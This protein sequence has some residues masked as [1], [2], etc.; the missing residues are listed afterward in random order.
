MVSAPLFELKGVRHRYGEDFT[1]DVPRLAVPEGSCLGLVGPNGS[2]K[3]TLLR[4]LGFIEEP[5]EG[6]LYYRG[7][8]V[9]AGG[10]VEPGSERAGV[11]A[12]SGAALPPRV[13]GGTVSSVASPART[14]RNGATDAGTASAGLKVDTFI[15]DLRR[16]TAMLLQNPYL[17]KKSV[18]ENVVY[19]LR[20][21][22]ETAGLLTRAEEALRLVGLDP[23]RYLRRR[24]YA[25][26]GG[27]SHR[28][29]LAARLALRPK[30]LLLDEPT[31]SVDHESAALMK[32]AIESARERFGTTLVIASH[33][34]VWLNGVSGDTL[35]MYDGRII[36]HGSSNLLRG[37]WLRDE[38]GLWSRSLPDG[39]KV[40]AVD[41]PG[42]DS[43]ALLDPTS[44]MLSIAKPGKISAQN[45]LR[46]RVAGLS[47]EGGDA[48]IKVEADVGGVK[49]ICS[50]TRRAAD[51]L[52]L[53]PGKTVWIVFKASSIRWH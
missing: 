28:V 7:V 16:E 38:R 12:G 41:P 11:A 19:G 9:G 50:V 17:L 49:F 44:V 45:V 36:E 22:R 3:S 47:S 24:W 5:Q 1:L 32:K 15:P 46:G 6:A 27:E 43:V 35:R 4:I 39:Q 51:S 8:R 20:V 2:G 42:S 34:L 10:K 21:R 26:S 13:G 29:A 33:D 52:R 31:A 53:L 25:L 40:L 23:S 30:T 48:A 14:G 37:P 18:F